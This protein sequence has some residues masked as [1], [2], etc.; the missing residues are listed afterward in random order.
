MEA[1]RL[2]NERLGAAE[3]GISDGI[4]GAVACITNYEVVEIWLC[5]TRRVEFD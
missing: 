2:V 5:N 3:L 4:V 1:V